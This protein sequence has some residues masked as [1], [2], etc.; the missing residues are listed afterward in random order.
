MKNKIKVAIA[1][2]STAITSN[3]LAIGSDHTKPFAIDE[4]WY[5]QAQVGVN[6]MLTENTRFVYPWNVISPELTLSI[7]KNISNIW[8]SRLQIFAGNNRGVYYSNDKNS[9]RFKFGQYGFTGIAAFNLSEYL[10]RNNIKTR[11]R[12]WST[13]ALMGIGNIYTAFSKE[14]SGVH[15]LNRNNSTYIF[16]MAGIE[17]SRKITESLD[18]TLELNSSWMSDRY[19]GQTPI[20]RPK[21]SLDGKVNVLMGVKYTFG[22]SKE[23]NEKNNPT[24][25]I[26]QSTI[27]HFSTLEE[28]VIEE[29][30]PKE[31][32]T[33]IVNKTFSVEEL[34]EMVEC[35]ESIKG[36]QLANTEII[37]F[38]FG[39]YIIKPINTI[40]LDKVSELVQKGNLILLIRG[41]SS[42]E[43]ITRNNTLSELRIKAVRDYLIKSGIERDQLMF[44]HI[45]DGD[46]LSIEKSLTVELEITSL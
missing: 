32:V 3:L 45:L 33:S 39:S 17:A 23:T 2:L 43:Q 38:D 40:Y 9:P 21:I 25:I 41:Y 10:S 11:E 7:G 34:I 12:I 27:Q 14:G 20:N 30:K 36:K 46:D 13:K 24:T 18:L 26:Q 37:S 8:S 19:N 44:Q 22:R 16:L 5:I 6:Y 35:N 4:E 15:N 42:G 29:S 28:I 31:K 1:I